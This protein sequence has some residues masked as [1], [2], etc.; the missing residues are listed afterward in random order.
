MNRLQNLCLKPSFANMRC[1]NLRRCP[2]RLALILAMAGGSVV[3][4]IAAAA[5]E[6]EEGQEGFF[7]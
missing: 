1:A 3:V 6:D 4:V 2:S 7:S 5:E